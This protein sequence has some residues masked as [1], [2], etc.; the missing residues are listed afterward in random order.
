M[1][2]APLVAVAGAAGAVGRQVCRLLAREGNV[3]VRLGGRRLDPLRALVAELPADLTETQAIDLD[4]ARALAAFCEG[5]RVVVGCTGPSFRIL[6]VVA[7]AA[8]ASGADYVD[9]GGDHPLHERLSRVPP[10][11]RRTALLTAGLMPGLSALLPRWLARRTPG[12]ARRLTAYVGGRGRMTPGTAGDYILSLDA[13]AGE[14]HAAWRNG[15]RVS[16]ALPTLADVEL[17]YFPGRVTAQ[18]FLSAETERIGQ[19][20]G[21]CE[22]SWYNVF[23]G[24]HLLAAL[25]RLRQTAGPAGDL[26]T[27]VSR[28]SEA[29]AL[30][31]FGRP[32]YQAFVITIDGESVD[33]AVTQTV[34]VRASDAQALTGTLTAA[35]VLELLKEQVGPG[36]FY[37]GEVLPVSVV[38]WLAGTPGVG[39][40]AFDEIDVAS[41][42]MEEAAV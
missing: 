3:R 25:R 9:P 5:C 15:V 22:I 21:L 26:G 7:R 23:D 33:R 28:L 20:L 11:E 18:P 38:E 14:P 16:R 31:L 24:P 40:E 32:P 2:G 10:P 1:T 37:A 35:A 8:F 42:S 19:A 12:R 27:M 34:V 4:D 17:P 39:L 6:D 30:D 29:A 13:G 36:V 41:A